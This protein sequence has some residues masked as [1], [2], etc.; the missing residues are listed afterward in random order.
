VLTSGLPVSYIGGES[1]GSHGVVHAQLLRSSSHLSH[2]HPGLLRKNVSTP[3]V[4]IINQ[5]RPSEILRFIFICS[6]PFSIYAASPRSNLSSVSALSNHNH[7]DKR[8]FLTSALCTGTF[9]EVVASAGGRDKIRAFLWA[10]AL[11]LPCVGTP[12]SGLRTSHS[13]VVKCASVRAQS[14]LAAVYSRHIQYTQTRT[15]FLSLQTFLSFRPSFFIKRRKLL[16]SKHLQRHNSPVFA[17]QMYSSRPHPHRIQP[18]NRPNCAGYLAHYAYPDVH[19]FR[20]PSVA[21]LSWQ[22]VSRLYRRVH[23]WR[24][25][26]RL[27][28]SGGLMQGNRRRWIGVCPIS[29]E[30]AG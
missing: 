23:T 1:S 25:S 22:A 21:R 11:T 24:F 8:T 20:I 19:L 29:A 2:A 27:A 5:N 7:L 17:I 9:L 16:L 3:T 10:S 6:S 30:P 18:A 12:D 26:G 14:P 28:V 15:S 4:T 13:T